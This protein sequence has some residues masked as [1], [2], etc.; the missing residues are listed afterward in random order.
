MEEEKDEHKLESGEDMMD[1]SHIDINKKS[2]KKKKKKKNKSKE[3]KKK[4]SMLLDDDNDNTMDRNISF[5]SEDGSLI[6]APQYIDDDR[7]KN[8]K[9]KKKKKKKKKRSNRSRNR[10]FHVASSDSEYDPNSQ[11]QS[12][13]PQLFQTPPKSRTRPKRTTKTLTPKYIEEH[14][15]QTTIDIWTANFNVW[16][17]DR[18]TGLSFP[19]FV[20]GKDELPHVPFED[21]HLDNGNWKPRQYTTATPYSIVNFAKECLKHDNGTYHCFAT[22]KEINGNYWKFVKDNLPTQLADSICTYIWEKFILPFR[23]SPFVGI[24]CIYRSNDVSV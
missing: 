12:A 8:K 9:S 14:D 16:N 22:P 10:G 23:K 24:Q 18:A 1:L 13:T 5:N 21:L 6:K 20:Q 4:S 2:K 15:Q 3:K 7:N 19:R 11:S 17:V